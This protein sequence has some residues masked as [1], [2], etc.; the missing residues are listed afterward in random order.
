MKKTIWLLVS[1]LMITGCGN[2]ELKN[3]DMNKAVVTIEE[4]LKEMTVIDK[5]S[6][7][8]VY[9]MNFELI[10]DYVIKENEIGELY[11]IIHTTEKNTV[12]DIMNTYFVKLRDFSVAYAPERIELLDN[13]LEKEVGDYLI[14]IVSKDANTVYND[15]INIME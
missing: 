7:E 13:R 11:A 5:D 3:L 15:I 8:N 4:T 14:Y 10:K 1:L 2:E 9:G 12:K 6:L